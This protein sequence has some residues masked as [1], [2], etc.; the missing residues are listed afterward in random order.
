[1]DFLVIV[2]ATFAVVAVLYVLLRRR[3]DTSLAPDG[4]SGEAR[5]PRKTSEGAGDSGVGGL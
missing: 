3:G 4:R 5:L 1:M 2:G